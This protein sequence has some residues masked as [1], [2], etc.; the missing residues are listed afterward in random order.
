MNPNSQNTRA[1]PPTTAPVHLML[2]CLCDAFYP[3]VGIASVN[4]L[5]AIG[6]GVIFDDRQTC[7]G[8]PA[9]N[10]G[11]R[12]SARAVARHWLH[13]FRDAEAIVTPSGSCAAMIRSGF[14]LL[15]KGEPEAAEVARM[16]GRTWEI[17]EFLSNAM[18]ST[19]WAGRYEKKIALHQ[20][21][22][23]RELGSRDIP[24]AFLQKLE[25]I[26]LVPFRAS[27]QCCGFG[28]VFAVNFP[29][30][31]REIGD[32]KLAAVRDSGAEELVSTDMGCVMHLAGLQKRHAKE[33]GTQPLPIRHVV[34]VLD[35]ART[36]DG[37]GAG[38]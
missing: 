13:V 37:K 6:F 35:E 3:A 8:Q 33:T 29:W 26:E 31:S 1:I 12:E 24:R 17:V 11:D 22:H 7:C 16:A 21:C 14:P 34:E 38:S 9:F 2:T 23:L 15:F 5:E 27:E 36:C 32:D 30:I 19:P 25:G 20:S 18:G 10:S 4:C 28:G